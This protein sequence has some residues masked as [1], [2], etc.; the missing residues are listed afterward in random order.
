[1]S[2]HKILLSLW[3]LS[4]L[5]AP[6]TV[7]ADGECHAACLANGSC[8]AGLECVGDT[9]ENA[10]GTDCANPN[11]NANPNQ[12][13]NNGIQL[14]EPIGNVRSIPTDGN[15][16][17]GVFSFYFNTIYP[18]IIGM[19]A[20]I[21]VLNAVWGGFQIIQAGSDG[22]GLSHGKTRLLTSLGGLLLVLLSAT[23]LN[24]INPTFFR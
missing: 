3:C 14:L 18:W 13:Q 10:D 24:V 19:G 4:L 6:L 23:L 11:G 2:V 1:M 20:G 8:N 15:N 16:G 17:L 22:E 7:H 12:N 21:A 9:C 5:F